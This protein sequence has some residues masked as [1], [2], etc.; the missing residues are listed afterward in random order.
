[1]YFKKNNSFKI[2]FLIF[3]F[4]FTLFVCL[5]YYLFIA[6]QSNKIRLNN[7][8]SSSFFSNEAESNAIYTLLE[9]WRN[10]QRYY[11]D[12]EK[13]S[14][15]Q[16]LQG[17][18]IGSFNVLN[19]PY[20]SYLSRT[21]FD[22]LQK[23]TFNHNMGIGIAVT[24]IGSQ[25]YI[26]DIISGST[27]DINGL[28]SWDKIISINNKLTKELSF[29]K[30]LEE[31]SGEVN[32]YINLSIERFSLKKNLVR[33]LSV[34]LKRAPIQF[35]TVKYKIPIDKV[36]FNKTA[37]IKILSFGEKTAK[38]LLEAL[39][40]INRYNTK[41]NES[42]EGIIIDLRNNGGGLIES[43]YQCIDMFLTRGIVFSIKDSA[44][45][46]IS[47]YNATPKSIIPEYIPIIT[48]INTNSASASELFAGALK[49]AK[50]SLLLGDRS[51]G[52]FSIQRVFPL[53]KE[54]GAYKLTTGKYYLA[55]GQSLH[56]IGITPDISIPQYDFNLDKIEFL[57][58]NKNKR[59]ID[60]FILNKL[61]KKPDLL[62]QYPLISLFEERLNQII[63]FAELKD[64]NTQITVEITKKQLNYYMYLLLHMLNNKPL[65]E[66]DLIFDKQLKNALNFLK[67]SSYFSQ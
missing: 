20:S 54:H 28:K 48:L 21:E 5:I 13:I 37:Y 17:S 46:T 49:T 39:L 12:K 56:N 35:T 50:R 16:L 14:I 61:N 67:V 33:K 34:N 27:A 7:N 38:E 31:L 10:I 25:F 59:I 2:R 30:I 15:N 22:I 18:L 29:Y 57:L 60:N 55:N 24:E 65:P 32:S 53:L 43:A 62:F 4:T 19:D 63:N 23:Q 58:A 1:M 3:L 44:Q 9:S 51:F 66:V 52:K 42:I 36:N 11:I 26:R 64:L 41:K 40:F 8:Q 45:K 6:C 47:A